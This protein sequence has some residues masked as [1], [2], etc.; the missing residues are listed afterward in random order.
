M[1]GE[2]Q[3][4]LRNLMARDALEFADDIIDILTDNLKCL[5]DVKKAIEEAPDATVREIVG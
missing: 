5:M 1:A 3:N 2:K 4:E